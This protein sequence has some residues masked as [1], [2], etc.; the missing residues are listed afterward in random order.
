[1]QTTQDLIDVYKE[2]V[3]ELNTSS[4]SKLRLTRIFSQ[5]FPSN[6]ETASEPS[7]S[8]T[9]L[10]LVT[11][12]DRPYI[13]SHERLSLI[14]ENEKEL[15]E[16]GKEF[17]FLVDKDPNLL[18]CSFSSQRVDSNDCV[19]KDVFTASMIVFGAI[20]GNARSNYW[21]SSTEILK[22]NPLQRT[23]FALILEELIE[24][25][26]HYILNEDETYN[27]EALMAVLD[28]LALYRVACGEEETRKLLNEVDIDLLPSWI[29]INELYN[30]TSDAKYL[31]DYSYEIRRYKFP[32]E[33]AGEI[34]NNNVTYGHTTNNMTACG[35]VETAIALLDLFV[36]KDAGPSSLGKLYYNLLSETG[37]YQQFVN[38]S[39]EDEL[40]E[41]SA[42][43]IDTL[44]AIPKDDLGAVNTICEYGTKMTFVELEEEVSNGNLDYEERL[45]ELLY[46]TNESEFMELTALM[47][48]K[49][50][51]IN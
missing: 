31:T 28:Y 3:Y 42:A 43:L 12:L 24:A 47:F 1:M 14:L 29:N 15:N 5:F 48:V 17:S 49:Y 41:I 45:E 33:T 32:F 8:K 38:L 21:N 25:A 2:H 11:D 44:P 34:F 19:Y 4:T 37:V 22:R 39:D 26:D 35:R 13:I 18:M 20:A 50:N 6:M 40:N 36:D 16:I 30:F 9:L 23:I 51:S 46:P 27:H 7:D 10:E